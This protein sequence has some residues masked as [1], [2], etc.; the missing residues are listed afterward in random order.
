MRSTRTLNDITHQQNAN[1]L[2]IKLSTTMR[3]D[4][5]LVQAVPSK[6][7]VLPNLRASLTQSATHSVQPCPTSGLL[8]FLLSYCGDVPASSIASPAD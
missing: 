2:V 5:Y 8:R 7:A 3:C 4:I 6:P 1:V